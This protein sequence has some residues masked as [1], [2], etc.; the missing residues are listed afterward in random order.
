MQGLLTFR[1]EPEQQARRIVKMQLH[2]VLPAKVG[3][4]AVILSTSGAWVIGFPM[5][6]ALFGFAYWASHNLSFN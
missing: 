5:T 2:I 6:L 3:I 4:I 1:P